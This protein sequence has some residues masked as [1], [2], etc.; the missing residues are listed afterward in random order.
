MVFFFHFHTLTPHTPLRH[1]VL[2][3]H[4]L[5]KGDH[6]REVARQ[7][8]HQRP[9]RHLRIATAVRRGLLVLHTAA[10]GP[11][12]A[13]EALALEAAQKALALEEAAQ[14]ALALK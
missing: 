5:P 9:Q 1:A 11:I 8:L 4:T 7:E 13:Q 3:H 2:V 12:A 14:E 10:I 6:G